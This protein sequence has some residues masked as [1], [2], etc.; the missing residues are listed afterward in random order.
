MVSMSPFRLEALLV[1][2]RGRLTAFQSIH[3][4]FG[5]LLEFVLISEWTWLGFPAFGIGP[6]LDQRHLTAMTGHIARDFS[7]ISLKIYWLGQ[8][9]LAALGAFDLGLGPCLV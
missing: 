2:H 4:V 3:T 1:L 7:A 8:F 9:R 5:D 6:T